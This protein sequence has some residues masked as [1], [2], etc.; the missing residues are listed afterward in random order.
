MESPLIDLYD[1]RLM[2]FIQLST[3]N[4]M[5]SCS[6]FSLNQSDTSIYAAEKLTCARG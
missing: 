1:K 5:L 4:L 2:V 3:T 6:A